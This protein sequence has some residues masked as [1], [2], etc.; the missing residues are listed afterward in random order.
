MPNTGPSRTPKKTITKKFGY[1]DTIKLNNATSTYSYYSRY[2][3]PDITKAT[4][5]AAQFAAYELWR[6]KALRV[7]IQMAQSDQS[8]I[9]N[10]ATNVIWTAADLG[11]NESV[12]GETIMQY[13]N[14]RK[15][16]C[17]LNKWTNIVNTACN[18]NA[19]LNSSE[20]WNY[21]L[22]RNTWLNTSFYNSDSYSG[23][24]IFIQNF[25]AQ[26]LALN[27]QAAFTV[28]TELIVEFMQPAFQ[29][30]AS[31]FTVQAFDMKMVTEPNSSDPSEKRTYVFEKYTVERDA[32]GVRDFI[33]RFVREDGGSGSLTFTGAQLRN[34]IQTGTSAPYFGGRPIIYD[35]PMPPREI[36]PLNY[37]VNNYTTTVSYQSDTDS[38]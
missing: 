36:P 11:A 5:A 31:S 37:E 30:N 19:K 7:S 20:A 29:S 18:I 17:S 38:S 34:A 35:G 4:G 23:Y 21:I 24:Q 33:I 28:N 10:V 1:V 15:N 32:Q 25:G 14:A 13:S 3:K 2:V 26:N 9:N 22:P 6:I 27:S 16:T 12:S 8:E